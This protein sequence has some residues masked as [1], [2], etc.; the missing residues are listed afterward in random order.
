MQCVKCPSFHIQFFK[1][2]E[3]VSSALKL[4]KDSLKT[5]WT[6]VY[7]RRSA[8]QLN[9]GCNDF[10]PTLEYVSVTLKSFWK[11]LS[12]APAKG[13]SFS[14]WLCEI[15]GPK[16]QRSSCPVRLKSNKNKPKKGTTSYSCGF[17]FASCGE[18]ACNERMALCAVDCEEH[19][20]VKF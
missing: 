7:G 17:C 9:Q 4:E 16:S 3:R 8:Q 19:R 2:F 18:W 6:E 12:V 13:W 11:L 14:R 1:T 20:Q 5:V 15:S 10:I